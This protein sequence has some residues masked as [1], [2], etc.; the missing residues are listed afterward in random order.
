MINLTKLLDTDLNS[1]LNKEKFQSKDKFNEFV[2]PKLSGK[3]VSY[4]R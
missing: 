2:E 1:D 3:E 4:K